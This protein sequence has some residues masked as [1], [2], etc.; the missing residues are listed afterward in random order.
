MLAARTIRV[1][2]DSVSQQR[3]ALRLQEKFYKLELLH[4]SDGNYGCIFLVLVKFLDF[5]V[6][7]STQKLI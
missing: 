3:Q 4:V 5:T 2:S 1:I 7:I 6:R